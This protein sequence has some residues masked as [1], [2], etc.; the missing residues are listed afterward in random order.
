MYAR[1]ASMKRRHRV[2]LVLS[3]VGSVLIV[4]GWWPDRLKDAPL[5]VAIFAPE[6]PGRAEAEAEM[7]GEFLR[8]GW[9][10]LRHHRH[11][12]AETAAALAK[13]F[14]AVEGATA[15]EQAKA[16]REGSVAQEFLREAAEAEA[17]GDDRRAERIRQAMD[18]AGAT[19][20]L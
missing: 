10:H 14:G 16:L 7:A 1:F 5:G 9:Q 6:S 11:R 2:V 3:L 4:T 8:D 13:F 18:R 15:I 12:E 17:A 19:E 20:A